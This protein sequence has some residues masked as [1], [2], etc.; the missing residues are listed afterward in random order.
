MSIAALADTAPDWAE[1][2]LV[3]GRQAEIDAVLTR[4]SGAFT[5]LF[6]LVVIHLAHEVK[7][8]ER[9]SGKMLPTSCPDRHI[10]DDGSFCLG[11][12]AG[13]GIARETAEAWWRKLHGFLLCQETAAESGLWPAGAQ[14]SHGEAGEIE[15]RAEAAADTLGLLHAYR[16]AVEF[17]IGPIAASLFKI[18]RA[19]GL[20]RNGRSA[21]LCGRKDKRNN[22]LLRRDCH[23][24]SCPIV[25]EHERRAAAERF[26][27]S[28]QG[29]P[30]C[31]TM[32]ECPLKRT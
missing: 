12:R 14:I 31:G 27:R 11:L 17:D 26:W 13:E 7:V 2:R 25:L 10:N 9:V 8:F 1:L 21:C 18:N 20:L 23:R 29:R 6:E 32:R 4:S 30:C 16:E 15:L 3:D 22:T 24:L 28:M 5:R 19:T